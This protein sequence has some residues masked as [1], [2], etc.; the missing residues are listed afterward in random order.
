MAADQTTAA[1]A[2]IEPSPRP[3]T[4]DAPADEPEVAARAGPGRVRRRAT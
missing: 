2:V 3:L 4:P 1:E